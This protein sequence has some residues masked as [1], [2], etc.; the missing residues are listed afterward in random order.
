[1]TR[2]QF[3]NDL[4]RRL[5]GL[6]QEQAEQHLTYYA[7]MLA[8]RM[9]E[10]MS[11]EQA[12]ESMEDVETIARRILEEEGL[13]SPVQV[14]PEP[15]ACPDASRIPG[16]GGT[17]AYQGKEKRDWRKPASVLLW[18]LA[19]LCALGALGR[20]LIRSSYTEV[21]FSHVIE[22]V[23]DNAP[24]VQVQDGTAQYYWEAAKDA[25]D[26]G[27]EGDGFWAPLEGISNVNIQLAT[28]AVWVSAGDGDGIFL[29][30][31]GD[32]RQLHWEQDGSTLN[33][34]SR[35]G[36]DTLYVAVPDDVL[37]SLTINASSADVMIDTVNIHTLDITTVSGDVGAGWLNASEIT[38]KTTSG[39]VHFDGLTTDSL[40][41]STTSG[42]VEGLS[43]T[44]RILEAKSISGGL[45]MD[46][47]GA[48]RIALET[49]SGGIDLSLA[50]A[51][52]TAGSMD[53]RSRSGDIDLGLPAGLGFTLDFDTVS[54]NAEVDAP[55]VRPSKKT[56]VWGDGA[57]G[58]GVNTVSGNLK[59]ESW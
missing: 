25:V 16:G 14:P 17:K 36:G 54:G 5:E 38:V 43:S 53:L 37:G 59:M 35:G 52:W 27:Y 10:G 50:A 20:H 11:E 23:T 22:E 39:D 3:L 42:D 44:A 45:E 28:G 9:E 19:I 56:Y 2:A 7:E 13:P 49:T 6:T 34:S 46:L 31:D 8:D 57:C 40:N 12:V 48:E 33:I 32:E 21:D 47:L 1:M 26:Y 29:R 55:C 24:M 41:V 30:T 51:D 4:Y 15:P 18:I 58:I